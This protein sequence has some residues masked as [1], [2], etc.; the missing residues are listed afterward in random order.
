M[1]CTWVKATK[2][3]KM[4]IRAWYACSQLLDVQGYESIVQIAMR[5]NSKTNSA[6][7]IWHIAALF[8]QVTAKWYS[9]KA[10]LLIVKHTV[11][12]LNS[13]PHE[14]TMNSMYYLQS[15]S[16]SFY[17]SLAASLGYVAACHL[18]WECYDNLHPPSLTCNSA[19]T[20]S[21]II[22]RFNTISNWHFTEINRPLPFMITTP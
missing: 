15:H 22:G 5:K 20:N 11:M 17:V 14:I 8:W 6:N 4:Y 7:F 13:K 21:T 2:R 12:N 1:A 3:C 16:T 9:S 18:Y 10:S 19:N